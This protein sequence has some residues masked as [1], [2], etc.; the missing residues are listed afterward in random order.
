MENLIKTIRQ[1]VIGEYTAIQTPFGRK[2]LVYCDYT[3]SGRGLTIVEDFIRQRVLPYYANIHTETSFTG[4]Q[5]TALREQAR[6]QIRRAVNGTD[7]DQII[8][9]GAGATS[10]INKLIDILNLRLPADLNARYKLNALIPEGERPVVFIGPYEHHS[11][12]LPWRESIAD[13]QVIPLSENGSIDIAVLKQ[14][15]DQFKDRPLKV[16]SFSA[17]SNVTGI[18]TKVDTITRLLHQ[19]NALSLW[20]YAAAAPYTK[21]DVSG[22][23]NKA[24]DSSKDAVFISPHK[25]IGGPGTP[26][27]LVMKKHLLKNSVP[28]QPGGG[29]VVYVNPLEHS[30]VDNAEAREEGGTPAIIESIRAGLVFKLQQAVGTA[31][32]EQREHSFINR[33][34]ARW[35]NIENIEIL[36]NPDAERLS[37][38]SVRIKHKT[39]DLHYGYVVALLNDLFGLQVRGGCSCAGP[40]GH[41]LLGMSMELS[42][43]IEQQ[44]KQGH[45]ILRQGWVRMNFNFFIDE[46][47]FEYIVRAIELVAEHGWRLLPFYKFDEDSGVWRYQDQRMRLVSDLDD[48]NDFIRGER[49]TDSVTTTEKKLR[50]YLEEAEQ[51]LKTSAHSGERY[52]ITLPEAAEKLRWFALP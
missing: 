23:T 10:A 17:A 27:I 9:C 46:E 36:G 31:E 7:D 33:A 44:I 6:Q 14:K 24:G 41:K 28:T 29:T 11:N 4:A 42:N 8:F 5:T 51:W 13:L 22:N 3:A 45:M 20:D 1:S 35:Q 12:E 39:L 18:K 43:E 2:P 25:F 38:V 52:S 32:I 48:F 50:T 40:Y 19:Y 47:T 49:R 30:Y 34:L 21:I 16:G 26:G 37:I 15:L